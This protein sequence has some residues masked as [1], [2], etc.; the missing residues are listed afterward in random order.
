[1]PSIRPSSPSQET[2]PNPN[3]PFQWPLW[4]R[5]SKMFAWTQA[6]TDTG[7]KWEQKQWAKGTLDRFAA[8]DRRHCLWSCLLESVSLSLA[9]YNS[10]PVCSSSLVLSC[11]CPQGPRTLRAK[12]ASLEE[13]G[14]SPHRRE[15]A[16]RCQQLRDFSEDTLCPKRWSPA[17]SRESRGWKA[18]QGILSHLHPVCSHTL[19][20][21]T[22]WH[23]FPYLF[24][25]HIYIF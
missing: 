22:T 10:P 17:V 5:S 14:R 16:S 23:L 2:F 25:N 3:S 7:N 12:W 19:W 6:P 1:M 11:P 24:E 4:C 18:T 9:E 15:S 20:K 21:S 8:S 13:R